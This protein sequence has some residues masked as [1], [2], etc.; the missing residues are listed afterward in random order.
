MAGK[1]RVGFF[2]APAAGC[3]TLVLSP[4]GRVLACD[5]TQGTLKVFDIPACKVLYEKRQFVRLISI[6]DGDQFPRVYA[7][8]LGEVGIEFSPDGRYLLATTEG[9]DSLLWN[10]KG[11]T[12]VKVFG[13]LRGRPRH[14]VYPQ[15]VFVASN[16]ILLLAGY[17]GERRIAK[18]VSFPE[19]G[20]LLTQKIPA[21]RAIRAADPRFVLIRPLPPQQL[22]LV[23]DPS[24]NILPHTRHL[25]P[26]DDLFD[27]RSTAV[28]LN[29][30]HLIESKQSLI[31]VFGPYYVAQP[32]PGEVGLYERGKGLQAAVSLKAD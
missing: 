25:I 11:G 3:G 27:Q 2:D 29:S 21:G 31:D 13:K 10:V 19:G 1:N 5:D 30:G 7:G 24:T 23:V 6:S 12:V 28:E 8:E 9:G 22:F 20:V 4:D 14:A 17:A 18:L 16:R 32:G 15:E 26:R